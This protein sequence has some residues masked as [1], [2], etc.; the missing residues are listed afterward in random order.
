[1]KQITPTQQMLASGDYLAIVRDFALSKGIS[2]STLLAESEISLENLINPPS[3]VNNLVFNR[4]GNNLYH[5]LKNPLAEAVEF[6]INMT[7]A[8]HGSL[9]IAVL[10]AP[11][12][13]AAYHVMTEFFNTRINSHDMQL[14]EDGGMMSVS[15][16]CK[17]DDPNV[18]A[19]VQHFFDFATL[20][21][22]A[23]NTE[24]SIN[25]EPLSGSI[26][27]NLDAPEPPGF[28][29]ALL[30][31]K[32]QIKFDQDQLKL[33][34]PKS[35]MN[36]PLNISN[37]EL[38]KAA[39]EKCESEMRLLSPKDLMTKVSQRIHEAGEAIPT[40]DALAREFYMSPATFKRRLKEQNIT[41]QTLKNSARLEQ[42]KTLILE[43][44]LSLESISTGLGFSD[45]SNFTKAF[46]TWTGMTPKAFR[47]KQH[48][49]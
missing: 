10:C 17:Y 21:S 20:I 39:V 24:K 27:L 30:P 8:S 22:V 37:P 44:R 35:W 36:S 2:P 33:R 34:I 9:G 42:A 16:I 18:D 6:G 48:S 23:T 11:N 31:T 15:L 25:T 26:T 29:H 12:L 40:L 32:V 43:G 4:V 5:A 45:A 49:L 14:H 47:D 38:A 7:A 13:D 46:K 3:F 19:E 1:M 41:Y 28:P